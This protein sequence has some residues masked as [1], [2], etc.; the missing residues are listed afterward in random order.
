M[1]LFAVETFPATLCA[2][3][4]CKIRD[5]W[6]CFPLKLSRDFGASLSAVGNLIILPIQYHF[7]VE[8]FAYILE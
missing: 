4:S 1:F 8:S 2:K 7:T 3:L 6:V 5:Y